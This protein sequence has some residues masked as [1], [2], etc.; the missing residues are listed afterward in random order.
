MIRHLGP[1]DID[2]FR[3][4]RLEALRREP[5]AFASSAAD[6]EALPDAEWARRL[7]VNAVF[8]D[9]HEGEPVAIM[10]LMRQ[11]A[12]KLAHRATVIMVYV[13]K[14]RRGAGHAKALLDAIADY[15][16]GTGVRLL[17]LALSAENP[18]ALRFYQ[19]EGFREIGR[20]EAGIL[21][22]GREIDDILMVRRIDGGAHQ[23]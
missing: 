3:R 19:R 10:G 20:V 2:I 15:A 1:E 12:S 13:R 8:V 6:W 21:H 14:D 7:T 11:G 22:E 18:Q 16:R 23:G 5:A 4:I 9:F 17:E